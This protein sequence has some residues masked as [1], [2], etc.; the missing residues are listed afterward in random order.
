MQ[1]YPAFANSVEKSVDFALLRHFC[2][3]FVTVFSGNAPDLP[4]RLKKQGIFL[5]NLSP[6]GTARASIWAS[7][8]ILL[9]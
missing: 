9:Q 3:N 4:F 2:S 7:G 8:I 5:K 1:A 6:T